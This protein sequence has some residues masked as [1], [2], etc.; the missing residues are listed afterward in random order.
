MDSLNSP[1]QCPQLPMAVS[2]VGWILSALIVGVFVCTVAAA[3]SDQPGEYEVKAAFLFNFTKFVE[4]P[5]NAFVDP[6]APIVIG[7]IGDDPFGESLVRIVAG[8]KAQAAASKSLS[9][10]VV[11]TCAVVRFFSSAPP[12]ASTERRSWPAFRKPV[13]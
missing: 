5:E 1:L 2:R 9:T 4:W 12:N 7:I 13:S 11:R 6:H 3:Q 10:A 8:Q